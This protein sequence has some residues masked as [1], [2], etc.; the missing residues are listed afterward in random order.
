MTWVPGLNADLP[1]RLLLWDAPLPVSDL[2]QVVAVL[3]LF[4]VTADMDVV[5]VSPAIRYLS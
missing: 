3:P 5:V 1:G 2:R 4:L